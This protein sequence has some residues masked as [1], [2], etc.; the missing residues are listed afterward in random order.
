V[1]LYRN[2]LSLL[3]RRFYQRAEEI[4]TFIHSADVQSQEGKPVPTLLE[5]LAHWRD[6]LLERFG[7]KRIKTVGDALLRFIAQKAEQMRIRAIQR[8]GIEKNQN[9]GE[10]LGGKCTF[11]EKDPACPINQHYPAITWMDNQAAAV[12]EC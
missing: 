7:M 2:E 10:F 11:C 8:P 4:S 9:E 3:R 12:G 1:W 5:F 6:I